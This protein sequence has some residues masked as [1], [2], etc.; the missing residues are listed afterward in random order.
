MEHTPGPWYP[1]GDS[2]MTD[3]ANYLGR[4]VAKFVIGNDEFEKTANARLIAAAPDM[5]AE[6]MAIRESWAYGYS[7]Y[8]R[9]EIEAAIAKATGGK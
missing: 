2:V 3:G 1:V 4:F 7:T 5:L 8:H 6:L 9:A